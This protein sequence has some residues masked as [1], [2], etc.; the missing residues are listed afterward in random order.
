VGRQE[1]RGDYKLHKEI[2][3]GGDHRYDAPVKLPAHFFI[4]ENIENLRVNGAWHLLS[5]GAWHH[6]SQG[7]S[8]VNLVG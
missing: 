3:L 7:K 2:I 4:G 8:R 1:D 5:K 6:Y